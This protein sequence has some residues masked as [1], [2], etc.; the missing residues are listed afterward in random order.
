MM[1]EFYRLPRES[2]VFSDE[3]L[4]LIE[5]NYQA[6]YVMDVPLDKH[7]DQSCSLFYTETPHPDGSNFF[8]I[9]R[10]RPT[11]ESRI[12]DGFKWVDGMLYDGYVSPHNG[13][14]YHSRNRHD[15]RAVPG[16]NLWIDGGSS[17][18]RVI[19]DG[20]RDHK[21]IKFKINEQGK[22]VNA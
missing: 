19:G 9:V 14:L 10:N 17:Y 22:A 1:D 4:R 2:V 6:V 13:M 18:F 11:L 20:L 15:F 7:S 3:Q 16:A 12:S 5:E 8:V 21:P